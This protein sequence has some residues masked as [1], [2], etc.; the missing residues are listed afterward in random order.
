MFRPSLFVN[1][2]PWRPTTGTA[3]G[4]RIVVKSFPTQEL[5]LVIS[6][7]IQE[8]IFFMYADLTTSKIPSCMPSDFT[9]KN[10]DLCIII[11]QLKEHRQ[12]IA[13]LRVT[14]HQLSSTIHDLQRSLNHL[15]TC[16]PRP[17][18][19]QDHLPLFS[20]ISPSLSIH[21]QPTISPISP[22]LSIQQQPNNDSPL[23]LHKNFSGIHDQVKNTT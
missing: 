7:G 1:Q 18:M 12:E 3:V 21:Q 22:T 20:P 14:I 17:L 11:D 23:I 4:S 19:K 13:A 10:W 8:G 15:P 2:Q 9:V 6:F 16:Q 5:S